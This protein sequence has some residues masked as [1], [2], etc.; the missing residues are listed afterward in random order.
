ML[1]TLYPHTQGKLSSPPLF[2]NVGLM[3][4]TGSIKIYLEFSAIEMHRA[5]WAYKLM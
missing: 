1:S 4:G 3:L 5:M 2:S